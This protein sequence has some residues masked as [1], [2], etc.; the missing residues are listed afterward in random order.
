MTEVVNSNLDHST[1]NGPEVE[2]DR[3]EELPSEE[4]KQIDAND[5][6]RFK[7]V[8]DTDSDE[9]ADSDKE[10]PEYTISER[11]KRANGFK[12]AGNGAFK[13]NSFADALGVYDCGIKMLEPV[14]EKN[15]PDDMTEDE[16]KLVKSLLASLY[17]NKA[18]VLIKQ[19]DWAE[20]IRCSSQVL[21]IEPDNVKALYRR[22]VAG[23]KLGQLDQS[24]SDFTRTLELDPS[25]VAAKKELIE[26]TKAL[27][28][29][30]KREKAVYSNIFSKTSVYDDK[31]KE[32]LQRLKKEE[33]EKLKLQDEWTQ[34]KLTRRAQGLEEQTFEAWKEEK[35]PI[36]TV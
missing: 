22:A 32:R 17:G 29:H 21:K 12:E 15:P 28:E 5:Y 2:L 3:Q 35:V 25:N 14:S 36:H 33:E 30:N 13:R 34:S 11:I 26:V 6:S 27:K 31:E 20:A 24:K 19:E 9:P 8:D 7:D 18:M 23:F 10:T 1:I 16:S 4:K